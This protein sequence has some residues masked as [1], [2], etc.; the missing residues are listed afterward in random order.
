M[1]FPILRGKQ[2]ELQ[3]VEELSDLIKKH[4]NVCPIIEPMNYNSLSKRILLELDN[5]ETPFVLILNPSV[6]NL[7]G[8]MSD[9]EEQ[10][11]SKLSSYN[12]TVLGL[13][14]DDETQYNEI[15][16]I[17]QTFDEFQFAIYHIKDVNCTDKLLELSYAEKRIK[18]HFFYKHDTSKA[19]RKKFSDFKRVIIEDTYTSAKRN[20]DYPTQNEFSNIVYKYK[21]NYFGFGDF[22]TIGGAYS[23][24]GGPA[25]AVAL[26][27][28]D[29]D[30]ED[31]EINIVHFISDDKEGNYNVQGKY[32]Q[33]LRKLCSFVEEK[34][35][36][37]FTLGE[38]GFAT[39]L[40]EGEFH[41]LGFPKK[42]SIM[43]HIHLMSEIIK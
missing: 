7:A 16:E 42:L 2:Y 36:E 11:I 1:Y 10:I 43:H 18:Y 30:D 35:G 8:C 9:I 34:R 15:E 3:A 41:G 5:S 19:Y 13:I 40:K 14:V 12:T 6:G 25:H 33:A 37:P 39:N 4:E 27:L 21:K 28:T 32:F 31:N 22:Q 17:L 29:E 23:N 24:S 20:A 38:I 26:H